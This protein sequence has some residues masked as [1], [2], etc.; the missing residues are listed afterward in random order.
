MEGERPTD[1][2]IE[3][4]KHRMS[5]METLRDRDPETVKPV[6]RDETHVLYAQSHRET[7]P[8][9]QGSHRLR[10]PNQPSVQ[11]HRPG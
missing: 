1:M 4:E 5:Q 8:E 11:R 7:L 10:S 6:G 3:T 9:T 2:A